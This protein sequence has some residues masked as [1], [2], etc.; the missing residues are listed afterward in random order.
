V[1]ELVCGFE[2]LKSP[3]SLTTLQRLV[4]LKLALTLYVK[5]QVYLWQ[6]I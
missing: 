3:T 1:F 2:R 5:W 6:S 4:F